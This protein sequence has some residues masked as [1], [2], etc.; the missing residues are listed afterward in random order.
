[1]VFIYQIFAGYSKGNVESNICELLYSNTNN[2]NN[3]LSDNTKELVTRHLFNGFLPKSQLEAG[4]YSKL[5]DVYDW[6]TCV[7]RCCT[8]HA[9]DVVLFTMGR[10]YHIRCKEEPEDAC[11]PV[12]SSAAKHNN[13]VMV[14]I[15]GELSVMLLLV[16]V[17]FFSFFLS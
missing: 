8:E 14:V 7:S 13:T 4:D 11:Q 16:F 1:M 2:D 15:R 6:P 3:Q 12:K 17:F 9:C 10:C 5:K